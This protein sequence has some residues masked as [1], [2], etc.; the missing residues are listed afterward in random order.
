VVVDTGGSGHSKPSGHGADARVVCSGVASSMASCCRWMHFV[1]DWEFL[2]F[3][4]GDSEA[5]LSIPVMRLSRF[6]GC[7]GPLANEELWM[8]WVRREELISLSLSP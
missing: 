8:G 5:V 6:L 3:G 2:D 7:F 4:D 1:W